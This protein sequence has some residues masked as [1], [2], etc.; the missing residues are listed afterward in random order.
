MSASE[1]PA[2]DWH[3]IYPHAQHRWVMGLRP[4]SL[5]AFFARR[6]STDTACAERARWL[7]ED[8]EAYSALPAEALPALAETVALA[9][10]LGAVVD[11]AA[12][13]RDQ[14]LALGR[15]W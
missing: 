13:P 3:R 12:A 5:A 8:P 1:Q 2:I 10:G 14:L 9:R 15:A 11:P 6:E 4:G 7:A